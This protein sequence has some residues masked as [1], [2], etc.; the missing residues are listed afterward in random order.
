MKSVFLKKKKS[1]IVIYE[2]IERDTWM[3]CGDK[4]KLFRLTSK[5]ATRN[6]N[7]I[8]KSVSRGNVETNVCFYSR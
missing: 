5:D 2:P 4:T 3:F 8:Q 7:S 6:L 1:G